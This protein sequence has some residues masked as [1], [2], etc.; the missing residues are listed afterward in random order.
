MT[1][2][3]RRGR[4]DDTEHT[5]HDYRRR[6]LLGRLRDWLPII[7]AVVSLNS[8]MATV[9]W[10]LMVSQGYA[11]VE[12]AYI[13]QGLGRTDS[14]MA[15]HHK[16]DVDSLRIQIEAIKL[17]TEQELGPMQSKLNSVLRVV[18]GMANSRDLYLVNADCHLP[19]P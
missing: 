12:P 4:R 15:A 11:I 2:P 18:C 13:L 6:R 14:L 9:A 3:P 7:V 5:E 19:P 8:V 17:A 1:M 16:A 10:R